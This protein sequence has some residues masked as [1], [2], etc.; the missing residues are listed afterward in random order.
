MDIKQKTVTIDGTDYTFQKIPPRQWLRLRQR[1][2][3]KNGNPIDENLYDEILEHIVVAPK[4]KI[5]DFE[6]LET[7][8]EVMKEAITFQCKR[9]EKE[10]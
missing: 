10:Q 1:T 5:D 8:E 4:M 6:E 7:L 9:E 2:K 3:D